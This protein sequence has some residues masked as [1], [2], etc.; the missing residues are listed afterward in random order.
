MYTKNFTVR[1]STLVYGDT[2]VSC[3]WPS[4]GLM[5]IANVDKLKDRRDLGK[6]L[7]GRTVINMVDSIVG[8]KDREN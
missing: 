6:Y 4:S 7:L 3:R 5:G 2:L 8:N 1:V